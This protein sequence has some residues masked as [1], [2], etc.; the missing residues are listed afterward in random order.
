MRRRR[1]LWILFGVLAGFE[2]ATAAAVMG[3]E[4]TPL[5]INETR[6]NPSVVELFDAIEKNNIEKAEQ[7]LEK[8]LV[9]PNVSY[10]LE[11]T[12][13]IAAI[14]EGNVKMVASLCQYNADVNISAHTK[15]EFPL[16]IRGT[17]HQMSPL[18]AA[19]L[20]VLKKERKK[21]DGK[22]KPKRSFNPFNRAKNK[23]WTWLIPRD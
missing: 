22:E 19:K 11:G 17:Y 8:G 12:A 21:K 10:K 18:L 2:V 20:L 1:G 14:L 7:L 15:I 4:S 9:D 5:F 3:D 16:A 13:L 23:R 6:A